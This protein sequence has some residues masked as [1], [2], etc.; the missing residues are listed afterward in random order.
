MQ[1]LVYWLALGVVRL[2]QALPLP[3]VAWVGRQAGGLACLLD[4]RH[5][6]VALENLT[7]AFQDEKS[8]EELRALVREHFR[9]LGENYASAV[10]TASMKPAALARHV[11]YV[12]TEPL[13]A[14]AGD[15][16]PPSRMFAIGHFGN[17]ELYAWAGHFLKGY[18][19]V[20]TYRALRQPR[21]DALMASLRRKS[22]CAVFERR[23]DGA[24][25]FKTISRPGV[26]VGLLSDQHEGRAGVWLPFFGRECSTITAPAV[27]AQRYRMPLNTAI[28][29]RIGLA[30]WRVEVG[31]EIPTM[32]GH[33]RRPVAD[34]MG[35]VNRAFEAAI[36]RDPANWFWVHRRWKPKPAGLARPAVSL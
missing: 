11:E 21:L 9:R 17:F 34:V 4:R 22:G 32:Q 23:K 25:F 28:C 24:E 19:M 20:T 12:W 35:E 33:E 7:F 5:R 10:K 15:E 29:Y 36:R 30:R 16:A 14:P 3:V 27:L 1:A 18:R 31:P 2:L 8:P 13:P 6:R 26:F